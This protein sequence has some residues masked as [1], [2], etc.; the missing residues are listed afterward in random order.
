[1]K[2]SHV[3][4]VELGRGGWAGGLQ[5]IGA[6]LEMEGLIRGVLGEPELVDNISAEVILGAQTF[7]LGT[8][9]QDEKMT[10]PQ[11]EAFIAGFE[12][13]AARYL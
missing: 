6:A 10:E 5:T 2:D 1:M 7:L 4:E 13:T 9:L 12:Q 11:L 8:L 3:R